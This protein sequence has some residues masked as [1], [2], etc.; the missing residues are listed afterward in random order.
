MLYPECLFTDPIAVLQHCASS[1]GNGLL[2]L[3]NFYTDS[4]KASLV[5]VVCTWPFLHIWSCMS[6][7]KE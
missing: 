2:L 3:V 7:D 4:V 6:P 1:Y 5:A